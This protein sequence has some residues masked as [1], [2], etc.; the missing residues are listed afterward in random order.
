M[1]FSLDTGSHCQR[2]VIFAVFK[3][4]FG[5]SA[6]RCSF[7]LLSFQCDLQAPRTTSRSKKE[8]D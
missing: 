5:D 4:L 7:S 8:D 3:A 1:F 2:R 6:C